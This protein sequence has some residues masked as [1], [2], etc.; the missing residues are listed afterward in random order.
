M[1]ETNEL[2]ELVKKPKQKKTPS[3]Y[4]LYAAAIFFNLVALAFEIISA[5]TVASITNW[6]YGAVTFLAGFIP[7]TLHEVLWARAYANQLQRKISIWGAGIA[8]LSV[9]GV[10]LLSGAVNVGAVETGGWSETAVILFVIFFAAVH[11]LLTALY[12]YTD[13][14]IRASHTHAENLGWHNQRIANLALAG[15]ILKRTKHLQ[16]LK[17]QLETE[18]GSPKALAEVV[19]QLE[20]IEDELGVDL[21]GDGVVGRPNPTVGNQKSY[22]SNAPNMQMR[23]A[24]AYNAETEQ[25]DSLDSPESA[26]K[27]E[28]GQSRR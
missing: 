22:P 18:Y 12:F 24:G 4:G 19:R 10:A 20:G 14:G 13:D 17:R 28:A 27:V 1:N 23:T 2:E 3:N 25:S 5:V 7:L 16:A 9:L 6:G 26:P 11:G 21:T 15:D 8:V